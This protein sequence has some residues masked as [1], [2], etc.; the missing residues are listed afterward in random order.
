MDYSKAFAVAERPFEIVQHRPCVIAFKV[1]PGVYKIGAYRKVLPEILDSFDIV[2][3]TARPRL[4][5][6]QPDN[7]RLRCPIQNPP[8][9]PIFA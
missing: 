6:P 8:E 9:K 2:N 1:K 4:Q 7:L 5:H 3:S